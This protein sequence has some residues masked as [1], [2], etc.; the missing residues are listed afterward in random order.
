MPGALPAIQ[1]VVAAATAGA[2]LVNAFLV[3]LQGVGFDAKDAN[4]VSFLFNL[5]EE[6]SE[7]LQSDITDHYTETNSAIQDQI[8]LKPVKC[9]LHGFIG[10][11]NDQNSGVAAEVQLIA[12]QL[13]V[14]S[15]YVPQLT[16]AAQ[17][18]YN[19]AQQVYNAAAA[20]AATV[21]Q[22]FNFLTGAGTLTKQQQAFAFFKS[23]WQ[24]RALFTVQTP[25]EILTNMAIEDLHAVQEGDSNTISDFRVTFKQMNFASTLSSNAAIVGQGRYSF[26]AQ[27]AVSQGTQNPT[28]VSAPNFGGSNASVF[29]A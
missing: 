27:G 16:V 24:A 17:Q 6:D 18:F 1:G 5:R 25:W 20:A 23:R 9:T 14:F 11:L 19:E 10:E 4:S 3:V 7:D 28:P 22:A 26:Q 29:S 15:P 21:N 13:S 12:S 2:S 8:A